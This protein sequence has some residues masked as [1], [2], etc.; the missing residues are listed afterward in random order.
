VDVLCIGHAAWDITLPL[1]EFPAEDGKVEIPALVESGGGPAANAAWLLSWWGVRCGFA[2][3][4]GDDDRGRR[5]LAEFAAVGTDTSLVEIRPDFPTPLSVILV[6]QQTGS[7]TVVNRRVP[8]PALALGHVPG[9]PHVLLFDGH[10]LPASLAAM[11]RF[12]EAR[13]VLDAGSLR[14]GTRALAGRVE[15]LVASERFARQMTGLPPLDGPDEWAAAIAVLS[16]LNGR[17]VVITL[18]NRGL[19]HGTAAAWEHRPAAHVAA[20]DTTA[21]G[22][23]FHGALAY[24]VLSAL[25]WSETLRLAATTAELS[26]QALGGRRSFAPLARVRASLEGQSHER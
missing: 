10:E 1:A 6:N 19:L 17:P 22:D 8:S 25:S 11:D 13:T 12:P 18:G 5:V 20:A 9:R 16:A 26:V 7:R 4:V 23:A 24:G 14:D 2:G 15:F 21:A 3:V